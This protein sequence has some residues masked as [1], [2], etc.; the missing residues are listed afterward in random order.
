MPGLSRRA[1]IGTLAGLS[2][3]WLLPRDALGSRLSQTL[4]P[5]TAPTTLD[6]TI[7]IGATAQGSYRVL[8]AG[9]G[10]RYIPRVDLTGVA[11]SPARIGQRR[12]LFYC[13]HFSDIH[14]IDAQSPGRLEPLIA[15]DHSLFGGAFRPHD[16]LTTHVGAAMVRSVADARF[17]PLTGAP[18]AAAF[19][20]GDSADQLSELETRWYIQLLDGTPFV[21]NSGAPDVYEGV[22]AWSETY[23]A[24]HPD[25]PA[26]D[27][28]GD[29]GFPQVPGMLEAAVTQTVDSGGLPS[30]WYTVYGNHDT[31]YMGTFA[32]PAA[33]KQFAVGQHKYYDW[34]ALGLGYVQGWAADITAMGRAWNAASTNIG[35]LYGSRRVT[36][37][38]ARK[39]LE[40]RAFMQAHFSTSTNP[41]PV[42]H[43]FTQENLASGRTYWSADVG[44]LMRVFGLNTCNQIA[45]PDGAVPEEQFEWLREG[46]AQAGRD[47]RLC[48]V[49][50]HHNSL[51]LE[52]DAQLATNPQR[53]VHAEELIA[54][55]ASNSCV[56]AWLNGH[57]HNNTIIAHPRPDGTPGGFWEITT[58]SCIDFPQQQQVLEVIDNRDGTLSIFTTVLDHASPTEWDGDLSA[59]GLASLSRQLSANDWVE[60]PTMR[61]GSPLDRNTELLLPAPFDLSRI[62]DAAIEQAQAADQ[63]RIMAWES[64]WPT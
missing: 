3:T 32:V 57:T 19:V 15:F 8:A 41:G 43:G 50:S 45:G 20:T 60:S 1:L 51:T 11:P 16:P 13:G 61:I 5:G 17:S 24:Y 2:A 27:W 30:P 54:L 34:L 18:L 37:D 62:T 52:N 12:S 46:L 29:Y 49:L 38:P 53:L 28:F 31:L 14:I 26:G 47:G 58:A 6:Q 25:D 64:G 55:L 4:V 9:P 48:F 7:R 63:A 42:G 40:Q 39:L 44:P 21:P 35:A 33:L 10:E 23:W 56:I 59:T 36:P 22:Q